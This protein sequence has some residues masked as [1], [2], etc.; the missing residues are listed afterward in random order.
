MAVD[1]SSGTQT[2]YVALLALA[3]VL[4]SQSIAHHSEWCSALCAIWNL[5]AYIGSPRETPQQDAD[6]ESMGSR[7]LPIEQL[8]VNTGKLDA[9]DI[10]T[11]R[12]S[13]VSP[14]EN[15]ENM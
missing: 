7:G 12:R 10:L 5:G 15:L 2:I 9:N 4:S 13:L 14:P 3:M 8:R 11:P 1:E 6:G